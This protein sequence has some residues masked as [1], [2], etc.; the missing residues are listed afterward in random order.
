MEKENIFFILGSG[1]IINE[2][3]DECDP[4][5]SIPREF[6][7]P[8]KIS[9]W[10]TPDESCPN[11]QNKLHDYKA[12][13]LKEN[14]SGS[15]ITNSFI[16]IFNQGALDLISSY[17]FNYNKG[18]LV[19]KIE[20]GK[21]IGDYN[22]WKKV[23]GYTIDDFNKEGLAVSHP[24]RIQN[25]IF[26]ENSAVLLSD[27]V[28]KLKKEGHIGKF[29]LQSCRQ[30]LISL[31]GRLHFLGNREDLVDL[32]YKSLYEMKAIDPKADIYP[33]ESALIN[34]LDKSHDFTSR[35]EEM[36]MLNINAV[37]GYKKFLKQINKKVSKRNKKFLKRNK[38]F[39]KRSKK[40]A[41]N[42]KSK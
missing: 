17:I 28:Y 3:W 11:L 41:K 7:I 22:N 33:N 32:L 19:Y 26:P 24:Y 40:F 4:S 30:D 25:N 16:N 38:K 2:L 31:K 35:I 6:V 8:S 42:R 36:N 1:D 27:I 15:K 9:L 37:G 21:N 10:C 34:L 13:G 18:D 5:K 23:P 39:S 20:S 14:K 12:C 29:V